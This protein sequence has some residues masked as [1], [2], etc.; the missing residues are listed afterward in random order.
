M[1]NTKFDFRK[2]HINRLQID[3]L[4]TNLIN[5]LAPLVFKITFTSYLGHT[6]YLQ[7]SDQQPISWLNW[8]DITTI[9]GF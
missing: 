5:S 8:Y 4:S 9:I 3:I 2:R 1:K 7:L 6:V